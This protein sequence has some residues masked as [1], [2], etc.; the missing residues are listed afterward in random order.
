MLKLGIIHNHNNR[1]TDGH[2]TRS[3]PYVQ[4]YIKIYL[5]YINQ[6]YL[7]DERKNLQSWPKYLAQSK[8]I[9]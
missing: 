5:Q 4:K 1:L 2:M 9:Q 3:L 6:I 8:E 7:R